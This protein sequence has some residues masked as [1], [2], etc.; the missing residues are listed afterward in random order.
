MRKLIFKMHM[1]IDG[2]VVGENG[3]QSWL[4]VDDKETWDDLFQL[5]ANVDTYLLGG[6]MWEE[7]R[8]YWKNCLTD[9]ACDEDERKYSK[10]AAAT[11][12][13]VFSSSLKEAGWENATI[14]S[15]PA[16]EYIQKL[17]SQ[18]GKDMQVVGGA[19]FA[20]SIIASGLVDQ[21]S[22]VIVPWL[23]GRGKSIF[24]PGVNKHQLMRTSVKELSSG[25]TIINYETVR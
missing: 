25:V 10:M 22:F 24:Q 14:I 1:S 3:D 9:S 4:S 11:K 18:P 5:V 16:V 23:I 8:D 7:Y 21:Y 15:E 20:R 12:H 6:G 2:F 13:L 17:K 19:S